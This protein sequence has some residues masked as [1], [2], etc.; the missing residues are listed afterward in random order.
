MENRVDHFRI[1]IWDGATDVC[2]EG[3]QI[4]PF[5]LSP[6]QKSQQ[7]NGKNEVDEWKRVEKKQNGAVLPDGRILPRDAM[8]TKQT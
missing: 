4:Y 2:S 8:E 5:Q 1:G 7:K 3:I 6:M